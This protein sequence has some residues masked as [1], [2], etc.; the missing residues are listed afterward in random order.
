[1]PKGSQ[2]RESSPSSS[3]PGKKKKKKNAFMKGR[4]EPAGQN[5]TPPK[6]LYKSTDLDVEV[7]DTE[8]KSKALIGRGPES[9]DVL[10]GGGE[11]IQVN[12][13]KRFEP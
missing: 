5:K 10:F 8:E 12:E 11:W 3:L 7:L 9:G 6:S 2:A 4:S 1:M 13:K